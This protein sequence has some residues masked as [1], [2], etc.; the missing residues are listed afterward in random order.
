M[1]EA[2]YE[3]S[4]IVLYMRFTLKAFRKFYIPCLLQDAED[5]GVSGSDDASS[6]VVSAIARSQG[7]ACDC[8]DFEG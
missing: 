6:N 4:A 2:E 3:S 1:Y 8:V 5:G 7:D